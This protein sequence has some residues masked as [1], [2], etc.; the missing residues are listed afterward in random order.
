MEGNNLRKSAMLSSEITANIQ[1][2]ADKQDQESDA[3][4][5]VHLKKKKT[6]IKS[7]IGNSKK[8]KMNKN[9]MGVSSVIN[10]SKKISID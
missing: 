9:L 6:F 2:A 1:K 10:D 4:S 3:S 7:M 8:T 5:S